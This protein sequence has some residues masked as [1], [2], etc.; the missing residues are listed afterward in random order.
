MQPHLVRCTGL[1]PAVAS[2]LDGRDPGT[3]E[4]AACFLGNVV[5][6]RP[7]AQD[8]ALAAGVAPRLIRLLAFRNIQ[9]R[10]VDEDG[11]GSRAGTWVGL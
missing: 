3:I 2:Q 7:R 6:G 4:A 1:L 5:G 11:M 8:A 9:V 10:G